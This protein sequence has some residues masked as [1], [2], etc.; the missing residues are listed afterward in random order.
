MKESLSQERKSR[1]VRVDKGIPQ[2]TQ[3][4]LDILHLVGEQTAYRF[5]QLQGLL[6]R[7][8][9]T[10]S[11]DP[12]FL[13]ESRTTALI[14]RWK[15][16]GLADYRKIRYDEPGWIWLT[17]KG[18]Y[19]LDLPMKFLDPRHSDL[20][21]LFWVNETRILVE[22]TYG[23]RP[24]FQWESER[25]YRVVCERFKR[26]Q[27]HEPELWIPREYKSSHRPDSLIRYRLTEDVEAL[28]VISAIETEL[29]EKD[30]QTWKK[31]FLELLR[32]YT[33]TYYYAAPDIKPSLVKALA[34]FHDEEA[35]SETS[36][37]RIIVHDLKACL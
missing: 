27:K 25:Q 29:S 21:H 35:S 33:F 34:K 30:Y 19:H 15:H 32:C 18:L 20:D 10:Q 3:R 37:Q 14:G 28:E 6:A 31:I 7:H 12:A 17:R 24:G 1:K 11:G 16:L 4:D 36:R 9:D 13:S 2:L 22:T 5:D 23:T 8:P 26:E